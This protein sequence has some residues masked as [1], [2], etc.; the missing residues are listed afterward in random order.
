MHFD[1][2]RTAEGHLLRSEPSQELK[3]QRRK[4]QIL[5]SRHVGH[6][7]LSSSSYEGKTYVSRLGTSANV[8][9][10]EDD[11]EQDNLDTSS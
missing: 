7:S 1:S 5:P 3:T 6:S 11:L 9:F 4:E 8:L 10:N 2:K